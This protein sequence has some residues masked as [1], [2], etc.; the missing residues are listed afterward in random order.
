MAHHP[1]DGAPLKLRTER[2]LVDPLAPEP[3][4]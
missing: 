2:E 1:L 3:G 4:K